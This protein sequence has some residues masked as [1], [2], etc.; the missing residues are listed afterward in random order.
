MIDEMCEGDMQGHSFDGIPAELTEDVLIGKGDGIHLQAAGD[1]IGED[2]FHGFEIGSKDRAHETGSSRLCTRMWWTQCLSQGRLPRAGALAEGPLQVRRRFHNDDRIGFL[3]LYECDLVECAG[4]GELAGS[5][6]QGLDFAGVGV[7]GI[8]VEEAEDR[9][10]VYF[11]RD[12]IEDS[13][14]SGAA[15]GR[16][17]LMHDKSALGTGG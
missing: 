14:L 10:G 3:L 13:Q 5:F 9:L 15:S 6:Y 17:P 8:E 1:D 2:S 11:E 7:L 4:A 12:V 16:R